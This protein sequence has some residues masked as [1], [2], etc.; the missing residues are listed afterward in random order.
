M[1]CGCGSGHPR[2]EL[3]DGH[4]IFLTFVCSACEQRKLQ[5]YRS[6]ILEYYHAEEPIDED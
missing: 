5:S 6:D 1:T 3:R 4:G 2:R